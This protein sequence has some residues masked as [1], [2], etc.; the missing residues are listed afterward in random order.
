MIKNSFTKKKVGTMTLGEKLGR[1]RNE[2]RININEAS[3]LTRIQVAYLEALEEGKYD[4]LPAEVYVK[5][6]LKSYGDF[7]GV[8]EKALLRLY[9]KEKEIRNNLERSKNSDVQFKNPKSINISAFVLTPKK[10][11]FALVLIFV[12][13]GVFYLY[14]EVGSF[15]DN[16]RLIILSPKSNEEIEG[17]STLVEGITDRDAQIFINDQPILVNDDGKFK[18]IIT[19]QGGVNNINVKSVNKFKKESSES[20]VVQSSYNNEE[21]IVSGESQTGEN[22]KVLLGEE[23]KIE[24]RVDPG[25]VW[26]SVEADDN[27]VFSGTMLSGAAQIFKAQNKIVVNSGRANATY[28]NFNGKDIGVLGQES[29]AVR[30]VTFNKTTKY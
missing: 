21:G 15:T 30:G 3:R 7:L 17:N 4:K 16:P 22:E 6:F 2:K 10:M 8:D 25:P 11:V 12:F 5:G 19:L 18:E 20:L 23:I 24:I 1:L 29:G 27:L 13:I 14:R 26:L 9:E 28:I